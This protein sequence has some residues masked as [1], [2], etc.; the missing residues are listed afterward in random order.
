MMICCFSEIIVSGM[1]L[2]FMVVSV[3][4]TRFL[5]MQ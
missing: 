4:K 5:Q 2:N 3:V 1:N